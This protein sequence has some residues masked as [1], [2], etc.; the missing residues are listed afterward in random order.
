[1]NTNTASSSRPLLGHVLAVLVGVA[2]FITLPAFAAPLQFTN[3]VSRKT[4]AGGGAFDVPLP[5]AGARGIEPR[6]GGA[7]GNHTIVVTFNNPVIIGNAAVTAGTGLVAGAPTFSGNTM[8]IKL[9]GVPNAQTLTLTL[10]DVTTD[11]TNQ[12]LPNTSINVGFL[13]VIVRSRSGTSLP[14]LTN[15]CVENFD[16]VPAPNLPA[17]WE[18]Y[19]P[20]PGNGI[21]W[22]TTSF[23]PEADTAPNCA[24]IDD[25]DGISDKVLDSRLVHI[26]SAAAQLNFRNNYNTEY[27]PPPN[28]VFWDGGVLE[29]SSP[30]IYN[31]AFTDVTDP[32]VG[33]RFISGGYTGEINGVRGNLLPGYMAW[34][35]NSGGYI[36]TAINLGSNL[37]GQTVRFRFRMITDEAASRPGRRIDTLSILGATCP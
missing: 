10:S 26:T 36:T 6:T 15:A 33:G 27:D 14:P 31:G 2:F 8:T 11:D 37:N 30:N 5:L 7:G 34:S 17:G 12:V 24:F 25:Q 19:N 23:P 9:T 16:G 18:A 3:A 21:T 4:H 22:V 20:I 13:Q 28:E 1:M 32:A 35:G 29:V